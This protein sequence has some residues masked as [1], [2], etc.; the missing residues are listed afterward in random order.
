MELSKIDKFLLD[1]EKRVELQNKLLKENEKYTLVTVRVNYPGLEKSNFVTDEIHNIISNEIIES[2]KEIIVLKEEYKNAE[3]FISHFLINLEPLAVK[4]LM[5][6]IEENHILGRC[7]DIDVYTINEGKILGLSRKDLGRQGRKCFICDLDANIC[8]RSQSHSIED[9]K[10]YFDKKYKDY[11]KYLNKREIISSKIANLAL[12]SIIAEVS[13][14]PSFGLVSPLTNGSHKD[15]DYYTF[16]DSGFAIAPYLKK[17]A[18]CGYSYNYEK[19]IFKKIRNIGMCAEDEMFKATNGVNTHKGMIF[20][21]GIVVTSLAKA[22]YSNKKLEEAKEII[23]LMVENIL[24][25]F[26]NIDQKEKLTHGERLYVEYGFTGI[27][28]QVKDGLSFIFDDILPDY[29]NSDLKGNN[30]YSHTLL[31]LMSRVDDSTIVYRHNIQTLYKVQKDCKHILSI[32]GM[33]TEKGRALALELEKDYI[34]KYISPGGSADLLAVV[35]LLG[36]FYN[37][38]YKN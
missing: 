13:T 27:R 10:Q 33:N 25:D 36:E 31:K 37:Q 1:R 23:K 29:I 11:L 3:G 21:I 34:D 17:M 14:H 5:V 20:L 26:N 16:L 35:I 18:S 38:F 22:I 28:G 32:G 24:D 4:K 9:I 6:E 2:N 12:K 15:M 7:V 30:L 19:D 8:S